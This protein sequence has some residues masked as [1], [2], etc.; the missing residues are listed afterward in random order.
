MGVKLTKVWCELNIKSDIVRGTFYTNHTVFGLYLPFYI[1]LCN[2]LANTIVYQSQNLSL[3]CLTP[4]IFQTC[5]FLC[6]FFRSPQIACWLL[7]QFRYFP[8]ICFRSLSF[9]FFCPVNDLS[10]DNCFRSPFCASNVSV[11][12]GTEAASPHSFVAIGY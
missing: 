2:L 6:V 8:Q 3:L 9:Y 5:S 7:S 1:P 4:A 10:S 11:G 12:G